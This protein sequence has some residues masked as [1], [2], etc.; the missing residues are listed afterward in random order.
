MIFC[1]F[2]SI[3]SLR[4]LTSSEYSKKIPSSSFQILI[5][6]KEKEKKKTTTTT[7]EDNSGDS[8]FISV[9]PEK[10]DQLENVVDDDL[11]RHDE[12]D[13]LMQREKKKKPKKTGKNAGNSDNDDESND[14]KH[15]DNNSN[16]RV[17]APR[18]REE[19]G[20]MVVIWSMILSGFFSVVILDFGVG[21]YYKSVIGWVIVVIYTLIVVLL[22]TTY[23]MV[24]KTDT[25]VERGWAPSGISPEKLEEV[26]LKSAELDELYK[27]DKVARALSHYEPLRYCNKCN[28]YQPIRSHHCK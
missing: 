16:K 24:M 3:S 5:I 9:A 8:I 26:R 28:A 27:E 10:T 17:R 13:T 14:D 22:V 1:T 15:N 2:F 23:V 19:L 11:D 18:D 4:Q 25:Y 7:M 21:G 12:K 6:L 20:L